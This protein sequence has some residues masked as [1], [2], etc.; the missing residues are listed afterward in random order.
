M[1]PSG[2]G[3]KG[4]GSGKAEERKGQKRGNKKEKGGEFAPSL[5]GIGAPGVAKLFGNVYES[6]IKSPVSSYFRV[7]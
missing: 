5:L 3:G 2:E 7:H 6:G 1:H 4:T